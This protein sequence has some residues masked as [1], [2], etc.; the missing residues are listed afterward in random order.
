VPRHLERSAALRAELAALFRSRTRAE[1]AALFAATDACCTPVLEP[2]EVWADPQLRQRGL[3]GTLDQPG[4]GPVRLVGPALPN[5]RARPLRP[6]PAL[7]EHTEA[8]LAEAGYPAAEIAALRQAGVIG[9]PER[10]ETA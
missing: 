4:V 8:L 6:A 7:G 3:F 5:A 1:W 9:G 10:T 2:D